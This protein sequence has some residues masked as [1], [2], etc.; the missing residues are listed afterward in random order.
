MLILHIHTCCNVNSTYK[1]TKGSQDTLVN[2]M[3]KV[4][5]APVGH[6]HDTPGTSG[7]SCL[8]KDVKLSVPRLVAII[9]ILDWSNPGSY[10]FST[11]G[12]TVPIGMYIVS[13]DCVYNMYV[14]IIYTYI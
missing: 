7:G 4:R 8:D 13:Y 5:R 12:F 11:I 9:L 10:W 3:T 1:D 6:S 2:P 14:Y